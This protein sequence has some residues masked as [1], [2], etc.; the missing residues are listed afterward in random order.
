MIHEVDEALRTLIRDEA[1]RGT[2]IEVAF[3]APTKDWAARRNAPTVNLY[4]YDIREDLRRKSRGMVNEYNTDGTVAARHL[5]PRYVKLSYLLTAW[6]QRPEDEHRLLSLLLLGFIKY[7]AMP[8]HVMG[9]SIAELGMPVPMT[10]A[11]PPPEDRAFADVW[12]AL[13]GELKPSLDLVVSTPVTGVRFPAA[14]PAKAGVSLHADGD[15]PVHHSPVVG[16]EE[17]EEP[18]VAMR[19]ERR[20]P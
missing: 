19:R 13:G 14:G 1:L 15:E 7:E 2:D 12:T 4:L 20:V 5:P 9:G 6:T 3:E 18:R 11:L 16:T 10:V 17:E 8:K